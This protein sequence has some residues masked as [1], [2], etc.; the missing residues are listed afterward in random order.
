[1]LDY[2]ALLAALVAG[3]VTL[4]AFL[5]WPWISEDIPD[6]ARTAVA[7]FVVLVVASWVFRFFRSRRGG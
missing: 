6:L 4:A 3:V 2:D 7:Y 1:M 5:F